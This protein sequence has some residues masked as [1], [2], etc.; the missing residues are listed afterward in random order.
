MEFPQSCQ[1]PFPDWALL[2]VKHNSHDI[3]LL[4]ENFG[5]TKKCSRNLTAFSNSLDISIWP[6]S[7]PMFSYINL[8]ADQ[9]NVELVF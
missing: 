7:A 1:R 4:M 6:F 3:S 9:P 2:Q 8:L 5:L